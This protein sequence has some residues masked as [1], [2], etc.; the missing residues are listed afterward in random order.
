MNEELQN[1][2]TAYLDTIEESAATASEFAAEQMPLLVQEYLT[3]IWWSSLIFGLPCLLGAIAAAVLF[4]VGAIKEGRAG[5]RATWGF[6]CAM[7]SLL[8]FIPLCAGVCASAATFVKV[9]VA[10]RVVLLEKV[11]ELMP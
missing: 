7:I 10:P 6:P 2:L 3:W 1:R 5:G 4:F 9:S 11:T 8:A